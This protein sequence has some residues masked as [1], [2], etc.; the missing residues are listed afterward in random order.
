MLGMQIDLHPEIVE[1]A[2]HMGNEIAGHSWTHRNLTLLSSDEIEC[3]IVSTNNAIYAITGHIP[4]FFRS[5]Y[6]RVDNTVLQAAARLGFSA[7]NWSVDPR[8]WETRDAEA[9]FDAVM[10]TAFNGAIVVSHDFIDATVDAMEL[11]IPALIEQGYQL[12]TISELF[13]YS[14]SEFQ[15]GILYRRVGEMIR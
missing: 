9:I 10:R 12:V 5:P 11:I 6:G 13:Y 2:F 3:E 8:D 7:V 4:P 1:R 15:P 14:N